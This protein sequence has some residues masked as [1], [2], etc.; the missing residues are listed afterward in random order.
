MKNNIILCGALLLTLAF[1]ACREDA[2]VLMNY[3]YNDK[4]A[5]EE[6]GESYAGKFRVFWKAMNQGY[7]LWDYEEEQGLNWDAVYDEFLPKFEALD[8]PDTV[9]T[10]SMLQALMTDLI[11]PLHDG[12]MAV[13]FMNHQTGHTITVQPGLLRNIER[14]DIEE[15]QSFTG[16]ISYY[17]TN[18]ELQRYLSYDCTPV[19]QIQGMNS[20]G[21]RWVVT[22][23]AEL[24]AKSS[25]TEG[26]V[27]QYE[28]LS[29]LYNQLISLP[30]SLNAGWL[31]RFNAIVNHYS[32]L[33]VPFLEPIDQRFLSNG[34]RLR[35]ALTKDNIAYLQFSNF[36]LQLYLDKAYF[37]SQMGGSARNSEI[38]Q[39]V[40]YVWQAWFDAVQQLHKSGQLNGVIIDVRNNTGGMVSDGANVLGALLP[41]GD[42]QFGWGRYKRGVGRYDFS[43]LTPAY[44]PTMK[45]PHEVV[46]DKPIVVLVNGRSV[47]M[48]EA[49]SLTAK[50]VKNATLM[51]RTTFGAACLLTDNYYSSYNYSG[52]IG[53]QGVTPVFVNLPTECIFNM[54]KKSLEGIGVTPD[55]EV[56][57]DCDLFRSSG[58]DTQF[59]RALEYIRTGK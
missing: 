57:F 38:R 56:P 59:E 40:V 22:R 7:T 58:R 21:I 23:L 43:P 2:D 6:A 33:N 46:D 53:V 16:D 13:Q 18:G 42:L 39:N 54:D 31:D 51:G 47:S 20:K 32:Y 44:M 11:A 29:A 36:R 3:A 26:E 50:Q 52:H 35:Y 27:I 25:L 9:V 5:F 15:F 28:G 45:E 1:S 48:S 34:I 10:D 55:I 14:D 8:Q 17:T 12:H 24:E 4:S 37:E 19:G 41:A 30:S 49:T